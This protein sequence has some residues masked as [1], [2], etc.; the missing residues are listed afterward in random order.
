MAC[1]RA[2]STKSVASDEETAPPDDPPREDVDDECDVDEATPR[3]H[4]REVRDPELIRPRRRKLTIDQIRRPR[5]P[6]RPLASWSS[7][8]GRDSPRGRPIARIKRSTVQRARPWPSRRSC[9]HT[10]RGP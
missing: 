1:S 2:S 3:G 4:V 9:L 7:T 10:F 6:P 5:R 8:P